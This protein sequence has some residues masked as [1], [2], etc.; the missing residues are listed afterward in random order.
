M[1]TMNAHMPS[2]ARLS[3]AT[4][5]AASTLLRAQTPEWIWHDNKGQTPADNEVRFFRKGFKVDGKIGRASC[6]ERV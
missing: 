1:L 2:F 3:L 4:L 6:R 5:L